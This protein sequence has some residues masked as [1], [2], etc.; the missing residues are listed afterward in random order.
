MSLLIDANTR[1]ADLLAAHPG[2]AEH[3]PA[4][5]AIQNPVL[6]KTVEQSSTVERMA[7]LG[8]VSVQQLVNLLREAVGQAP[9]AEPRRV[10]FEINA[11]AMLEKGVHPIGEV[12][13][14]A[15]Q[16]QP[17]ECIRLESP[18]RP[19]PLI[20]TMRRGGFAVESEEVSPGRHFTYITR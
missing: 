14:R 3:L 11:T 12:R 7:R 1:I 13:E 10:R 9:A 5:K 20:E 2:A 8:G 6:R 15:A 16:L 4:L 17:G 18:F 19:E